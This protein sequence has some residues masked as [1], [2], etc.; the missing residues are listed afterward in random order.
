MGLYTV[1]VGYNVKQYNTIH[2]STV[3]Y[4]TITHHKKHSTLKTTLNT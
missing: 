4:N 2:Y 1:A 3:Q